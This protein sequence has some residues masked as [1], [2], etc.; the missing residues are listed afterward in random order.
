MGLL[1]IYI[2]KDT[3]FIP[4]KVLVIEIIRIFLKLLLQTEN[5]FSRD[6]TVL[7]GK[8]FNIIIYLTGFDTRC[9][10]SVYWKA[11]SKEQEL[12]LTTHET[13]SPQALLASSV[14][15]MSHSIY[16]AGLA[17]RETSLTL[18]CILAWKSIKVTKSPL[19]TPYY[20]HKKASH[21]PSTR[22]GPKL[23]DKLS[24][25]IFFLA[26]LALCPCSSEN[27]AGTFKQSHTDVLVFI[28]SET[29]NVACCK[30]RSTN[31]KPP[32]D[33]MLTKR[34]WKIRKRPE[35]R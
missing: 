3:N 5:T 18:N 4:N 1:Q 31:L 7:K 32:R 17:Y 33:H 16:L 21:P 26:S 27:F 10:H 34:F 2:C 22:S 8:Y 11:K 13:H 29:D 35:I 23:S 20:W 12:I 14:T 6:Y 25:F 28:C 15:I 30:S 19:P 24:G 9:L